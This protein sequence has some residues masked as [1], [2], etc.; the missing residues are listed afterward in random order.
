MEKNCLMTPNAS[1]NYTINVARVN[2]YSKYV[3]YN[4][5]ILESTSAM[6]TPTNRKFAKMPLLT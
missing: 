2:F 4:Q 6:F 1:V 3:T 5:Q